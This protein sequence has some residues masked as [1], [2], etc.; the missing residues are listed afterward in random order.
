MLTCHFNDNPVQEDLLLYQVEKPELKRF[1]TKKAKRQL[2]EIDHFVFVSKYCFEKT[3]HL[4]HSS[5]EVAIIHNGVNFAALTNNGGKKEG[6][7]KVEIINTGHIEKRKNQKLLVLIAQELLRMGFNNFHMT[8]LGTGPDLPALKAM[9][10][11]Q[12]A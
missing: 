1:L 10:H 3:Q 4:L 11:D 6:H 2:A 7:A 8:I 9:I 12:G 5:S